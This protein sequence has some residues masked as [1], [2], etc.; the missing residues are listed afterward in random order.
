VPLVVRLDG[1]ASEEGLKMLED[2]GLANVTIADTMLGAAAEAVRL[3]G[4]RAT[5]TA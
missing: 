5:V 2:A 3:A 4:E 1:T